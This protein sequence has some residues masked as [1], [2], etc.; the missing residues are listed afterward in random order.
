MVIDEG[1]HEAR[2]FISLYMPRRQP[3]TEAQ[4]TDTTQI[5]Q[6][7]IPAVLFTSSTETN[8]THKLAISVR[9]FTTASRQSIVDFLI[10]HKPNVS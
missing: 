4:L 10:K 6:L 5:R 2:Q 9:T 1:R 7:I 8:H 3:V